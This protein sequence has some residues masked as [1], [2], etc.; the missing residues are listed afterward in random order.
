M[1][2]SE[3]RTNINLEENGV[4]VD[5][6][7]GLRVKIASLNCKAYTRACDKVL[8]PHTRRIRDGMLSTDER[9]KLVSPIVARYIVLDWEGLEDECGTPIPY[10]PEKAEEIFADP[11]LREFYSFVLASANDISMFQ[12]AE[13]QE[14]KE[15][16]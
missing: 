5:F 11:S 13:L 2:L 15:N 14:S 4:W 12:N 7:E 10:S 16:L 1:K 9:L 8:K 6:I 3:I